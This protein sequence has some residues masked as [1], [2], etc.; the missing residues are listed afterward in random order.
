MS[1]WRQRWRSAQLEWRHTWRLRYAHHPLCERHRHETIELGGMVV[2]RG[3]LAMGTGLLLGSAT[4][5][6]AGGAWCEPLLLGLSTPLLLA[7]WPPWY[8]HLPRRLRDALRAGLGLAIA[9]CTY[10]LA[11]DPLGGWPWALLYVGSWMLFK[12]SRA[13]VLA[14]R[15]E[16]CPELGRGICSGFRRQA[17]AARRLSLALEAE[18]EQEL[19]GHGPP[20][21]LSRIPLARADGGSAAHGP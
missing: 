12:R 11:S 16:A 15:C 1:V 10:V 2:C 9:L 17:D 20:P 4:V 19:A 6:G 14:R 5:I 13:R 7:S 8:R 18:L 21:G 3:C